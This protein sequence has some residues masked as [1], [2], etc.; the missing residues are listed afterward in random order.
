[1]EPHLFISCCYRL[2]KDTKVWQ[3]SRKVLC[4]NQQSIWNLPERVLSSLL[5]VN[6]KVYILYIS[7]I[8]SKKHVYAHTHIFL[9]SQ[10]LNI[11][12][13]TTAYRSLKKMWYTA[14]N[15]VVTPTRCVKGK[16][17]KARM[18]KNE[19]KTWAY[20]SVIFGL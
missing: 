15:P 14:H 13:H 4:K 11:Y 18:L 10:L 3:K 6:C 9:E 19:K 16:L 8:F 20:L 7:N 5:F 1:M 12:Q 2:T 17:C